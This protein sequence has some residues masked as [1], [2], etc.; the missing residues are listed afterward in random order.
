MYSMSILR[1]LRPLPPDPIFG[2]GE[3]IK[4]DPNPDKVDL[5]VGTYRNQDLQTVKMEAVLEAENLLLQDTKEGYLPMGGDQKFIRISQ[6][7][8][9][10][11]S[12]VKTERDRLI[13][14]QGVG[15]TNAL[16]IGGQLLASEVSQNLY[17]PN[18]SWPNHRAIFQSC[19]MIVSS[20]PYYDT[21]EKKVD[22]ERLLK[23]LK[24][25]PKNSVVVL[26]A[27]CHNPTG[28]DLTEEEWKCLSDCMLEAHLIPFFDFAY[29]GFGK[30]IE[31]DP[32]PIRYFAQK[33]HELFVAHS[34]SKF[35]GLYGERLGAVHMLMR[36]RETARN[37]YSCV[38]Q[39][40]RRNFSNPPRHGAAV[41][42]YIMENPHLK[43]MWQQELFQMRTRIENLRLEFSD[44]LERKLKTDKFSFL[45]N[46][47]G[48]FSMLDLEE[49]V[50]DLL[51][52]KYSIYVTKSGR[53]NLSGLNR[54]N[55]TYVVDA[56]A[57]IL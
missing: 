9:F 28:S 53:I 4:T 25:A 19:Q 50:V 18:L 2:M 48:L 10:G 23:C 14:V 20:Y 51:M 45:K 26:H 47:Y 7:L 37:G 21:R 41:V 32:W 56:I 57:S 40:V 49:K 29:Q 30:G 3:V 33:G 54:D 22:F 5:I 1:N 27:C 16:H 36:D 8:V 35:F 55:L 11:A 46:R 52:K 38:E 17:I 44:S 31:E 6:E 24:E 13:S 39:I 34:F 42:S 43:Q 15:G 12:F